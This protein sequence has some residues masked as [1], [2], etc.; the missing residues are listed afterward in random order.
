MLGGEVSRRKERV[1]G[2][3]LLPAG[4]S[5]NYVARW[6]STAKVLLQEHQKYR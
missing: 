4:A 3:Q 6:E 1:A 5:C 2:R